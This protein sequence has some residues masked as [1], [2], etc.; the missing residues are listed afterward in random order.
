LSVNERA[1]RLYDRAGYEGE[2]MRY[3]KN[4]ED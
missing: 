3:I 1:R 2:L 4:L